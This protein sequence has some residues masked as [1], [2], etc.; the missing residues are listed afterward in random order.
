M[1]STV[2][3]YFKIH[4]SSLHEPQSAVKTQQIHGDNTVIKKGKHDNKT[5]L[6]KKMAAFLSLILFKPALTSV[7]LLQ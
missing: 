6:E 1:F 4:L 3:A 7:W 5:T 2:T